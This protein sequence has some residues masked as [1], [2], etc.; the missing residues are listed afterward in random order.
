MKEW[1]TPRLGREEL[2]SERILVKSECAA[3]ECRKRGR[4]R[5]EARASC[6]EKERRWAG[7]GQRVRRS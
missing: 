1:T 4:L 6:E 2:Y 3:R 7:A 5:V